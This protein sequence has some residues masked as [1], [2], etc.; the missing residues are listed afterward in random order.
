MQDPFIQADVER[1]DCTIKVHT[2]HPPER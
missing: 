2:H 1:R